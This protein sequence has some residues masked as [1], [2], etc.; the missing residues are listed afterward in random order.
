MTQRDVVGSYITRN[1]L[2]KIENNSATPSM[3]TL[4]FLAGQL[5]LPVGY[6]VSDEAVAMVPQPL[7]DARDAF[8]AGRYGDALALLDALEDPNERDEQQLLRS[9]CH[10]RL[11]EAASR[12]SD[13]PEALSHAREA[14]SANGQTIYG[15]EATAARAALLAARFD[16]GGFSDAIAAYRAAL[17]A[18]G[19]ERLYH[20]AM[21]QHYL[22]TGQPEQAAAEL[23]QLDGASGQ[24]P[25]CLRIRGELSMQQSDYSQAAQQLRRAEQLAVTAGSSEEAMAP[26]YAMLEQCYREMEDYKE[27]YNYAAKQIQR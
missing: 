4:E 11:A 2:S 18:M 10:L 17:S 15:S 19:L 23:A 7:T 13:A 12:R 22:T 5:N 8:A 20:L 16:E 1:M 14:L 21:A 9:L 6:F 25:D 27:A 26:L 3:K 24:D